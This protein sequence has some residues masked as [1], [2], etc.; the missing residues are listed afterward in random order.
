M[1]LSIYHSGIKPFGCALG[2]RASLVHKL[3]RNSKIAVPASGRPSALRWAVG[4]EPE[5]PSWAR[6]QSSGRG[7]IMTE[8]PIREWQPQPALGLE[9]LR[10]DR[11]VFS[12]TATAQ[13]AGFS[14]HL[15][16]NL[17]CR[18]KENGPRRDRPTSGRTR[19]EIDMHEAGTEILGVLIAWLWLILPSVMAITDV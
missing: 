3:R 14:Q 15:A 12:S 9:D 1:P 7:Q 5:D 13:G 2:M 19:A 17:H 11:G 16:R 8:M 6:F 18:S 10:T 4:G